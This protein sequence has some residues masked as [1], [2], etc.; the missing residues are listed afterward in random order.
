M[1]LRDNS[2]QGEEVLGGKYPPRGVQRLATSQQQADLLLSSLTLHIQG[3]IEHRSRRVLAMGA[4]EE[5]TPS[6]GG[7]LSTPI[8]QVNLAKQ[9][10]WGAESRDDRVVEPVEVQHSRCIR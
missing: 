10:S 6:D 3:V 2:A 7:K 5:R 8:A 4:N 1:S 9:L